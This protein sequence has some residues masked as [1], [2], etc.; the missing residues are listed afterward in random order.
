MKQVMRILI[1]FAL[2]LVGVLLARN[3]SVWAGAADDNASIAAQPQ[4]DTSLQQGNLVKKRKHKKDHD[5]HG[6]GTVKPP[7][8]HIKTCHDGDY[9]VGGVVILRVINLE[10]DICLDLELEKNGFAIGRLPKDAGKLLTSRVVKRIYLH[11]HL[12]YQFPKPDDRVQTCFA[13]PPNKEVKIYF[14]DYYGPRFKERR[15]QPSWEP[16][17]TTVEDGLA[18]AYTD[19]SGV[20]ALVGK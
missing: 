8:G 3:N 12:Q 18:C 7:H 5:D 15:E 4:V 17:D 2:V 19:T 16:L 11:N 1:V 14:F 13:A 9:S 6:K 20:Y 10:D